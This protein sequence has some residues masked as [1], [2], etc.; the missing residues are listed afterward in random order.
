MHRQVKY[1]RV[2][3]VHVGRVPEC[4]AGVSCPREDLEGFFVVETAEG[5]I[6][7]SHAHAS[8]ADGTDGVV[9]DF[10]LRIFGGHFE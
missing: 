6:G 3:S 4:D 8:K 5:A 2:R 10:T 9:S 1:L 7:K